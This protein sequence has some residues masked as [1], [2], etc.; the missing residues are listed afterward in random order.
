MEVFPREQRGLAPQII[1]IMMISG[2]V[3]LHSLT[4]LTTN[5][6]QINKLQGSSQRDLPCFF[7]YLQ[8]IFY[9]LKSS[10]IKRYPK[11]AQKSRTIQVHLQLSKKYSHQ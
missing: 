2:L 7:I 6:Y 5:I 3:H 11:Q 4:G 10:Q 8:D 9:S 1:L